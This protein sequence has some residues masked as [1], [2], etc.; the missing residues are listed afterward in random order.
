MVGCF[1]DDGD[2]AN[3]LHR[4]GMRMTPDGRLARVGRPVGTRAAGGG[5]GGGGGGAAAGWMADRGQAVSG[6]GVA[7]GG[8]GKD[9]E[10]KGDA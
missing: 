3:L 4:L 9:D 1:T 10:A 5:G 8:D 2:R 7:S 6:G